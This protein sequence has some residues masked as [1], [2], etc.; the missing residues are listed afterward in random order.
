MSEFSRNLNRI[1]E[2]K[3]INQSELAKMTGIRQSSISDYLL[4]KYEPKQ[5]K[6]HLIALALD[7]SPSSLMGMGFDEPKLNPRKAKLLRLIDTLPDEAID[8]AE[9]ILGYVASKSF[10][11]TDEDLKRIDDEIKRARENGLFE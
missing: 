9:I 6:V 4:D 10:K 11:T 7:V 8:E 5:D 3:G 2:Q 1:M